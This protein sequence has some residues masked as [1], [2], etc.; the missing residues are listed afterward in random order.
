MSLNKEE[1]ARCQ[2][3]MYGPAWRT[4]TAAQMGN[5]FAKQS[6]E[7]A[8]D[9][10]SD[11]SKYLRVKRQSGRGGAH[12]ARY[13]TIAAAE[14]LN[15]DP[16]KTAALKL[17]VVADMPHDE[18]QTRGGIEVSILRMWESLFFDARN[19]RQATSWLSHHVVAPEVEAG[20]PE[21]ASKLKVAIMT[22]PIAVRG[23]LDMQRGTCLDEAD[24]LFQRRIKLHEKFDLCVNIPIDSD[25]AKKFFMKLHLRLMIAEQRQAAAEQRL[26]QR[27][28]EA[29]DRFELA[30]MRFEKAA[31]RRA[32]K[33][34]EKMR[35]SER[36]RNSASSRRRAAQELDGYRAQALR[37]TMQARVAESPLYL[38]R[39]KSE[40]VAAFQY[41]SRD[42]SVEAGIVN[43]RG[44]Q[45]MLEV[46]DDMNQI[47]ESPTVN[48]PK[49]ARLLAI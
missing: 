6:A 45:A 20:N 1:F 42:T 12:A 9:V 35:N 29:R 43:I 10:L 23:M 14:V 15:E 27:C 2:R 18:M 32:A 31:E 16:E 33:L 19:Q 41:G 5:R 4:R 39:W 38:L 25:S 28:A 8:D 3:G 47:D 22:G 11:F 21:L 48:E 36:R 46:I 37:R 34:N 17:M 24:R 26:A 30:K 44:Y 7:V 49:V 40:R 13:P